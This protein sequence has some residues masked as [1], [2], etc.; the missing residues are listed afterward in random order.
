MPSSNRSVLIEKAR[1]V[2][3]RGLFDYLWRSI[4]LP[5]MISAAVCFGLYF[6]AFPEA[7]AHPLAVLLPILAPLVISPVLSWPHYRLLKALAEEHDTLEREVHRRR[8]LEHDL[9]LQANTDTLT[10]LSNRRAFFEEGLRRLEFE[11]QTLVIIDLDFFKQV[12]DRYGHDIGDHVLVHI[13]RL[14]SD[15]FEPEALLARM[16]GEEFALL[17]SLR[18]SDL[19]EQLQYLNSQLTDQ[20]LVVLGR[21][22]HTSLSAGVVSIAQSGSLQEGI[23]AA[24]TYLYKAKANGRC[25]VQSA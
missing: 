17:S 3:K 2:A 6:F 9:R 14:L 7:F 8:S 25:Q 24:D 4:A 18:E 21:K 19:I 10:G 22:I 15:H 13:A 12:N 11:S 1:R 20:S 16:G 23:I 5:I